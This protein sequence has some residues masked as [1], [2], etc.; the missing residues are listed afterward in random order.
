MTSFG[1]QLPKIRKQ[2]RKDLQQKGWPRTKA[3][4][5]VVKLLEETHIRVGGEQY[6]KRNKTYG[7]S[8]LRKKHV[9]IYKDRIKFKF[10]GKKGKEHSVTLKN[11]RMIKLVGRCEEIPGWEL[12]HYYDE[13]GE[14]H[15]IDSGMVN[16][17]I[18][19]IA[20]NEFTAKD[21]RTWAA[22]I[23]FFEMLME[24]G[25]EEDPKQSSQ[26]VIEAI[27]KAALELGNTRAVCK[28]YYIHPF[29]VQSY[30]NGNLDKAFSKVDRVSK[31]KQFFSASEEVV[32]K[33]LK[34]YKPHFGD[35]EMKD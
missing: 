17:Y 30:E 35:K 22:S 5:L 16:D 14:K 2:V 26:N 31:P 19:R 6:A 12:F 21:F 15:N 13:H 10:I 25:I 3:L 7:L 27:D 29:L 33:L 4:A 11:R 34:K 8:T 20:G 1:S 9:D 18:H 28:K 32:L 24:M 23:I